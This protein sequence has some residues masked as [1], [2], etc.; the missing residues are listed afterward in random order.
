M[1]YAAVLIRVLLSI[2]EIYIDLVS[3]RKFTFIIFRLFVI[4]N[5][6]SIEN[7]SNLNTIN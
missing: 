3:V 2:G 7:N 4:L 1:N 5:I 6:L